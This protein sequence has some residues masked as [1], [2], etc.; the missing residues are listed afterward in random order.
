MGN[1]ELGIGVSL[2]LEPTKQTRRFLNDLPQHIGDPVSPDTMHA[3]IMYPEE[4]ARA[5][6]GNHEQERLFEVAGQINCKVGGIDAIGT[7]LRV[8][9]DVLQPLKKFWTIDLID[10]DGVGHDVRKLASDEI[11]EAFQVRLATFMVDGLHTSIARRQ[12]GCRKPVIYRRH[13]P[14]SFSVAGVSV[15]V[16]SVAYHTDGQPS[17]YTNS[18][19][20]NRFATSAHPS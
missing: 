2:N 5:G 1:H 9:R 6:I 7:E 17:S 15:A 19:H 13:F 11:F 20:F 10:E 3:T 12:N 8:V 14:Q 18:I 4:I 16:R